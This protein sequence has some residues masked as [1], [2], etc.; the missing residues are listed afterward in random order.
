M[1]FNKY[2]VYATKARVYNAMGETAKAIEYAQKV[3]AHSA[4]FGLADRSGFANVTRFPAD[5]EL[6]FGLYAPKFLDWISTTYLSTGGA[7]NV[8]QGRLLRALTELYTPLGGGA[9]IDHRQVAYFRQIDSYTQFIRLLPDRDLLRSIATSSKG[10]MLIRLP[11]MY[12][13]LAEASY[14][15][16]P[17]AAIEALNKVRDS[18][19]LA[20]LTTANFSNQAAFDKELMREYIRE[21]PG[22]GLSFHAIKHFFLAFPS[23]TGESVTP[24]EEMFTLPWPQLELTYGNH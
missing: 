21:T 8:D 4:D 5:R 16:D 7:G 18:R 9:S 17:A 23:L 10:I 20:P 11:E 19:G 13:I 14:P 22:E 2:A 3:I 12:Y 24:T 6:V 1:H 15:T